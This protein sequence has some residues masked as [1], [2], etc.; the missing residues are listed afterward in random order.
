LNEL[1]SYNPAIAKKKKIA[2]ITKMDI[3][4]DSD[5]K[6]L[7]KIKFGRGVMTIPISAVAG[8]GLRVLLDEVW[9]T[10]NNK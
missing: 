6:K 5:K 2:A 9:K 10:L 8:E 1:A 3:V 7:A 4:N